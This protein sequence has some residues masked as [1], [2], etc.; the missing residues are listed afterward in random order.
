MAIELPALPYAKE[1]LEPHTMLIVKGSRSNKME[2]IVE[3]LS[4]LLLLKSPL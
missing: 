2:E 4:T 1:A 3:A